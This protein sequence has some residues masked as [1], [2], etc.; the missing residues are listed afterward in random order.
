MLSALAKRLPLWQNQVYQQKAIY[1]TLNMCTYDPSGVFLIMECWMP[2]SHHKNVQEALDKAVVCVAL[3][4]KER[5]AKNPRSFLPVLQFRERITLLCY[6][7]VVPRISSSFLKEESGATVQPIIH[8]LE[9]N[10]PP[11]TFNVTNKFTSVFQNIVDAY[12]VPSYRPFTIITF[13]FLFA[14]MFGDCAHGLLLVLSAL[15]FILNERKIITK[16]QHIDNEIFNTFFSG[17][18]SEVRSLIVKSFESGKPFMMTLD[19]LTSYMKDGG[20]YPFG[21]DP[22]WSL[23]E[24]RLTFLNSLKMKAAVII[25]VSQMTFGVML[26][27]LNYRFFKSRVDII[28]VFIPQ[29]IFLSSVFI[30]L[31]LQI[32]VKWIFFSAEA[33]YVFG[34]YYP[35]S[36]RIT[37]KTSA[38]QSCASGAKCAPSLL[39]GFINMF[40]M[41]QRPKEFMSVGNE[42]NITRQCYFYE[43]YPHQT[44]R[45]RLDSEGMVLV[46]NEMK[47]EEQKQ[48]VIEDA[49][50]ISDLFIFQVIHTIEFVLGCVSH[51]ASY[52][53]LWA[54]SLAHAQLSEVLWDMVLAQSF[55]SSGLFGVLMMYFCF[56]F[57][58]ILTFAI[59]IIME[60]LSA[61]LHALRLH[62]LVSS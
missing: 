57:F 48:A 49:E 18:A 24:N 34:Q 7:S 40:M 2:K 52:L 5:A 39:I 41:K 31:C 25:G 35:V 15:F 30:Y 23:A 29:I 1:H 55:T 4:V 56:A 33:G 54:L 53:R 62:W 47:Q 60:G 38:E 27:F 10:E 17:R 3:F 45:S 37:P 14:V 6:F 61:F 58:A 20:P 8:I 32:V 28:T 43:W 16:Q 12:G 11:P 46:E 42:A 59:L 21:V 19:P 26:S 51:T 13:P 44:M 9:V 36:F 50:N 22:V